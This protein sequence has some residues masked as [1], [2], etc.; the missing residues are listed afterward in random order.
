MNFFVSTAHAADLT[1][2]QRLLDPVITH[3][4]LP[5]V[6]LMFAVAVVVFVYGVL[7]MVFFGGSEDAQSAGKASILYGTIGMFIMVSAWGIIYFISN[8]LK[9]L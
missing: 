5:V 1:T 4:V 9:A 6:E 3:V 2:V 8:T 7:Q